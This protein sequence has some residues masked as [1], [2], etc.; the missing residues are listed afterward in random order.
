MKVQPRVLFQANS[1]EASL[2]RGVGDLP[3]CAGGLFGGLW[4]RYESVTVAYW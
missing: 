2:V 3:R 4:A 1:E